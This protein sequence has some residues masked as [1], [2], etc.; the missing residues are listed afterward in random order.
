MSDDTVSRLGLKLYSSSSSESSDSD[1]CG[2]DDGHGDGNIDGA[3]CRSKHTGS[4]ISPKELI[5]NNSTSNKIRHQVQS[6]C[7]YFS[8]STKLVCVFALVH[9]CMRGIRDEG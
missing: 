9:E 5:I 3:T 7:Q 1:V 2:V 4:F 8:V 6:A